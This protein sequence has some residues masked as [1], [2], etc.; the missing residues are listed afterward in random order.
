MSGSLN[1]VSLIG[2]VGKDPEIRAF[3]NGG[4]VANLSLATTEMWKAKDGEKREA[5][6]WHRVAIFSEGLVNV[7][8]NY[9]HKGSKLYVQG[10]LQTRKYTDKDG[11]ERFSTEVVL[12]GFDAKLVLLDGKR[13]GGTGDYEAPPARRSAAPS[14]APEL[15]DE[16]PF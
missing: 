16:I 9:V 2:N 12:Q 10:K 4:E 14:Q 1:S 11:V 5:T 13:D 15:D 6:E 3:T 7:V 8:R